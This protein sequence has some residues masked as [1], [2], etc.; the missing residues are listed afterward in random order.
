MIT[1]YKT[2]TMADGAKYIS[3]VLKSVD[4]RNLDVKHTVIVPDRASLEAERALLKALGGSFN[5][6]VKTFRRLSSSILPKYDYLSK[7][8]GIMA[9]TGIIKDN[10]ERLTCF[11]KGVE[12][13]GFVENMYDT[14]SMMKYCRITPKMLTTDLPKGVQAKARDISV[15]YQAYLD[16]TK[17]RFVDSA[18]KMELLC[19][20][21][22]NTD[23]CADGYFYLYDFDNFSAQE[24]AVVE[25]LMLKSRGVYIACCVSDDQRDR[26]LYLND[27]YQGVLNVCKR[28]GIQPNIVNGASCAHK[29]AEQI[30]NNLFRYGEVAPVECGEYVTL[31]NGTTRMDE[32]YA[33]ACRIAQYVRRGG[34]YGD[35]YVVVSDVAKY[36]NALT[37]LNDFDIP[38]FCDRQF[39]LSDHPFS[40]YVVDF[41]TL[42]RNNGK[43]DSVLPFVKNRLFATDDTDET[44]VFMF[45]NYCLKY[46]VSYRYDK[47]SLGQNEPF[48]ASADRLREKFYDLY[49]SAQMPKSA[50]VAEYVKCVNDLIERTDLVEKNRRFAQQLRARCRQESLQ[51]NSWDDW[52]YYAK[53]TEQASDKFGEV[54]RMAEQVLGQ[55]SV[56][57]EEFVQI[58]SAGIGSVKISVI[59]PQNDCVIFANMAK[60]RKHD[61]KFLAL[62]GANYGAMPIVKG[63]TRLL[64]DRNIKDLVNAGINVEPQIITEN[65]RERFSL[66]QLL[67]EPTQQLY[68]SY[69]SADGADSLVPSPFVNELRALF[70]RKG[71]E[72]D[73]SDRAESDIYAEKQAML[74]LAESLRRMKDG[75]PVVVPSFEALR[76]RFPQVERRFFDQKQ[77]REIAVSRGAELYLKNAETSVSQLTDFFKCPYNFYFRYGLNVK[78]RDIAKMQ[79]ADLGNVLHAVLEIYVRNADLSETDEQTQERACEIYDDVLNDDFYVGMKNDPALTGVL[80]Q[81][82]AECVR[83]CGVVK[84][85]LRDSDF[86]NYATELVFSGDTAVRV[87]FEGGCFFLKGKVDRVDVCDDHFVII[88]YKS[89]EGA[90]QY[91]EMELYLGHKLQLPVY[92]KAVQDILHKKPAGFYYFAMHDNF[93]N[94][95][96]DNDYCWNGRT[97]KQ[98]DVV[99]KLD[100]RIASGKSKRLCLSLTK[101]G[102]FNR[103]QEARLLDAKQFDNQVAYAFELI[104]RAGNLMRRGYA[105]VNPY[106]GACEYCDYRAICDFDDI[107]TYEARKEERTV[108]KDAIDRTVNK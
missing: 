19:E 51:A 47:F 52:S 24:L 80:T 87:A 21:I 49:K 94:I 38:Y 37:V 35:V 4:K 54:L 27:I 15:I 31:F 8:A 7:Q 99:Q 70:C 62:L 103:Q 39:C 75:Q 3:T 46:N 108:D 58:L 98:L 28:N 105:S 107:Y 97:L 65:R 14:I 36:A 41:L 78:P 9:L 11:T 81:L 106:K 79:P 82:K 23:F 83:M 93:T 74:K 42:C 29:Y 59:P 40:R 95:T 50:T 10:R 43:L 56:K 53:V 18:D 64:S 71:K 13:Q 91:N 104:A 77:G 73:V 6:E 72:I 48:F 17:D 69:A 85:Q 55:R 32:V 90:S 20:A 88:D 45:E 33:L 92:V 100:R 89:G 76:S 44:G 12:T 34:R 67:L 16:F 63:D 30:A 25:Q 96:N 101:E 86:T 1:I 26:Y 2:N 5:A 84:Q 68:V 66:F 102:E 60:A 61:I 57:L 22:A